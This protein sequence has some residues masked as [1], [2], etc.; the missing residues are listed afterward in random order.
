VRVTL[1]GQCDTFDFVAYGVTNDEL[2]A[3]MTSV[4]FG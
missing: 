2:R 3:V 1:T 4:R